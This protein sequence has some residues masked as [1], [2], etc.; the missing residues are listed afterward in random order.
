MTPGKR[1]G[2]QL[3]GYRPDVA[4]PVERSSADGIDWF[5]SIISQPQAWPPKELIHKP[6][7]TGQAVLHLVL[8]DTSASALSAKACLLTPRGRFWTL[9]IMP[10]WLESKWLF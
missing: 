9:P 3:S 7:K 5:R 4:H 6:A 8:L 10:T 1:K 2:K